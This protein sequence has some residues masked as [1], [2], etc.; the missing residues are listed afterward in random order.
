MIEGRTLEW[1]FEYTMD[2]MVPWLNGIFRV[3]EDALRKSFLAALKIGVSVLLLA[4][5]QNI[6]QPDVLSK[7]RQRFDNLTDPEERQRLIDKARKRR[8]VGF[9]VGEQ[10]E[11]IPHYRRPHPAL[12]HTGKGRTIPRIVFRSG[13][14]V[15]RDKMTKVPTGYITPEGVEVEP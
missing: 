10:Y 14:V 2:N 11:S 13:C 4:G 1:F 8:I 7:D 15:H 6:I 3:D 12:F 5:D 9:R